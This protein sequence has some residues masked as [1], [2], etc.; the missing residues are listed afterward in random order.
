MAVREVWDP[1][2]KDFLGTYGTSWNPF[3]YLQK[4]GPTYG[5]ERPMGSVP[6]IACLYLWDRSHARLS[7]AYGTIREKYLVPC[8]SVRG[9][10][11]QS[12]V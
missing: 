3:S 4:R 12:H 10:W 9:P 2:H 11:D 7:V 8:K 1:S 5:C 6:C